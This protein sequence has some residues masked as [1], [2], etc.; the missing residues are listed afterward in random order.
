M[1]EAVH[2]YYESRRRILF[3]D[4]KPERLDTVMKNRKRTRVT[5]GQRRV[6]LAVFSTMLHNNT[7]V[8]FLQAF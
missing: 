8:I 6:C 1:L 4:K 5:Q 2:R 3:T 7:F